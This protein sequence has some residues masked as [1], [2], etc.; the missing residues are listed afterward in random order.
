MFARSTTISG[1]PANVDAG[2]TYIRDEVLPAISQMDG[3]VGM[4]FLVDRDGGRCIATTSWLTREQMDATGEMVSSL[5]GRA[6]EILG[7]SPT[8]DEWEVAVMHRDHPTH[9]GACCRVTWGRPGDLDTGLD[10]WRSTVL[11]ELE[12]LEGFCSASM[13]A[14]RSRGI[15]CGTV[16]FDSRESLE[17]SRE[18]AAQMRERASKAMAGEILDV[19][20]CELAVAHLRV[21]ELV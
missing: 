20:E 15:M 8:V 6:A 13:L 5:R 11:P 17:A 7:G 10:V 21:P 12:G 2:I 19:M 9:E 3:C 18:F 16:T 14:D 1:D 4:S